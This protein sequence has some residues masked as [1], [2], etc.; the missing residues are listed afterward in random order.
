MGLVMQ[1]RLTGEIEYTRSPGTT[2]KALREGVAPVLA[3]IGLHWHRKIL[4]KHFT[5]RGAREYGY[6]RRTA[7]Y[8]TNKRK[9]KGHS[10]PLVYTGELKRSLKRMAAFFTTKKGVKVRMRGPKY[11]HWNFTKHAKPINKPDEITRLSPKEKYRLAKRMRNAI[12]W[13]M[14][15]TRKR[16]TRTIR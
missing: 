3:E 6:Q 13:R 9:Y 12:V 15:N 5:Q 2:L 1:A 7:E 16:E 10:Q 8:R 11:L 4:P 14:N